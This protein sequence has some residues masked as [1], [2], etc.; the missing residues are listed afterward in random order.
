MAVARKVIRAGDRSTRRELRLADVALFV[1]VTRTGSINGAARAESIAPSQVSK[2]VARL[3]RH[4]GKKVVARSPQGVELTDDG[5]RLAP[6]LTDLLTR[7]REL[8]EPVARSELVIAAPSFLWAALVGRLDRLLRETRVH[9]IEVRSSAMTAFAGQD[10]FDAA[11]T[12]GVERWPGS[13]RRVPVGVIRR[14]LFATPAKA[15]TLGRP[16]HPASLRGETFVGRL[17]STRGRPVPV[18]DG[19]PLADR[20]R[21]LGHR[22][23]T[24]AMAL[25]A[26]SWTDELVFAPVVAVRR[27]VEDG[28]LVEVPVIGWDVREEAYVVCQQDRVTAKVQAAL[29]SAAKVELHEK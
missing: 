27:Y 9:A 11:F 24:V 14:A 16:V 18:P 26:A 20:D 29:V 17:D 2:A 6:L 10:F 7:A 22:V 1:Q 15:Q 3:E 21:R 4:L 28:R 5:R 19:C 12:V 8:R 25:E 13:W 23:E